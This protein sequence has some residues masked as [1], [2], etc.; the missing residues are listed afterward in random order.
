MLNQRNRVFYIQPDR[1]RK[2]ESGTKAN[3]NYVH[4]VSEGGDK[5]VTG[6]GDFAAEEDAD[7]WRTLSGD[8]KLLVCR[9]LAQ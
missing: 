6:K 5:M 7:A 8:F 3:E 2:E 4:P 1:R 9:L